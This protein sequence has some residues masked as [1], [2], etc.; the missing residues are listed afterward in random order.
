MHR[1]R[2][3]TVLSTALHV[4]LIAGLAITV[5]G[6]ELATAPSAPQTSRVTATAQ[7]TPSVAPTEPDEVPTIRPNPSGTGPDLVDAANALADLR[8]Y[9]VSVASRGVLPA[10]TPNGT[11]TMTS[12]LVQGN[13]PAAAFSIAGLDGLDGG[14]LDAIVIGDRA[15]VRTAAGRWTVSPGGAADFDATF[16]SLSPMDLV[17][18]FEVLSSV[19]RRVG[20]ETRNGQT[21][22]HLVARSADTDVAAAGLTAGSADL[23]VAAAGGSLVRLAIAGTWDLDGVPTAITLTIDVS[24]TNDPANR[25]VPPA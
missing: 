1:R 14:R 22:I 19:F 24:R 4:A 7:V 13:E 20:I 12:T 23:W 21:A 18:P 8:S 10:T 11:V 17:N 15:W 9:R 3:S 2:S 25:I 6:C 5:A 16:T